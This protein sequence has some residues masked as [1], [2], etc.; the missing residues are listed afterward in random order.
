MCVYIFSPIF[1]TSFLLFDV[2][3]DWIFNCV[4]QTLAVLPVEGQR[5]R[6]EL[7]E[8]GHSVILISL[9]PIGTVRFLVVLFAPLLGSGG[10][11]YIHSKC[12]KGKNSL[13]HFTS[14]ILDWSFRH[15]GC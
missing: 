12:E 8:D 9:Q 2:V 13:Y 15:S 4:L 5:R 11:R 6:P 14:V 10:Q 3:R 1:T 7:E